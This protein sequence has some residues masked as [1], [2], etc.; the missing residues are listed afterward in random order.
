MIYAT[1]T[2]PTTTVEPTLQYKAPAGTELYSVT[3]M[4]TQAVLYCIRTW[5][6]IVLYYRTM[7]RRHSKRSRTTEARNDSNLPLPSLTN[8]ILLVRQ[9]S[10]LRR[11][12]STLLSYSPSPQPLTLTQSHPL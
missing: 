11:A 3:C 7:Y 9:P 8:Y 2:V 1:R 5:I 4:R 12:T 10:S 6:Y